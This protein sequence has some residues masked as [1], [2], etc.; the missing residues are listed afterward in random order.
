[1]TLLTKKE[2]DVL[3]KYCIERNPWEKEV[4]LNLIFTLRAAWEREARHREEVER[5]ADAG[6]E[7]NR[8]YAKA[9]EDVE[10]LTKEFVDVHNQAEDA[11]IQLA[12]IAD[13]LGIKGS[14]KDW[15]QSI[16][17]A[18]RDLKAEV[19]KWKDLH[20]ELTIYSSGL[21]GRVRHSYFHR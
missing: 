10:R 20:K 17:G 2:V 7:Q 3:E 14:I 4:T 19:E 13:Q 12:C 5:L 9:R 16:G 6:V 8:L 11:D 21:E 15:L 1:M 18:I